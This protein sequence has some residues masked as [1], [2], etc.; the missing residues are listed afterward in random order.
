MQ[1]MSPTSVFIWRAVAVVV[2]IAAMT[3]VGFA[4][5]WFVHAIPM[6][7]VDVLLALMTGTFAGIFIGAASER[8]RATASLPATHPPQGHQSYRG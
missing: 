6:H 1:D 4:L 3:A 7:L 8:K 2:F 5:R